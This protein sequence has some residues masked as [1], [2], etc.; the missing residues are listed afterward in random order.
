MKF[1]ELLDKDSPLL[2]AVQERGFEE[3]TE[4][5]EKSI[6]VILDGK[7]VIAGASTGSGK[8]LAFASGLIRNVKMGKGLQGLVL[9]PTRELAEQVG[10]ELKDFAKEIDLGVAIVYGGVG[11]NPQI[12]KLET[13]EIVVATPGRMLD[14][15]ERGSVD[16]GKINTIVLD[17]AD[18]MLDMGFRD[19]VKKIVTRCPANDRQVLLFSATI[20]SDIMHL[21]SGFM[22]GAV[23]V[24]AEDKVDPT[25][26]K[27]VYYDAKD[28][29][30][31]SLLK[32]LLEN[33]KSH[34][35]LVFCNTR[36][37]VDFIVNNLRALDI[38]ASPIHGGITQDKRSKTLASFKSEN[39]TNILVATDVAARG[40]HIEGITHVY[41][42]DS[43]ADPKEYI[44]RIGRTARAGKEGKVINIISMRDYENFNNLRP[45]ELGIKEE[46]TP[47]V[48]MVPIKW[49]PGRQRGSLRHERFGVGGPRSRGFGGGSSRGGSSRGG[50]SRGGSSRD[51]SRG[52]GRGSNDTRGSRGSSWGGSSGG[53]DSGRSSGGR[54]SRDSGRS[55]GGSRSRDSGSGSGNRSASSRDSG[56][57]FGGSRG[58]D[59]GRSSGGSSRGGSSSRDSGRGYGSNNSRGGSR[60]SGR[61]S[62]GSRGRDSRT[63]NR[64][65]S[66][67][68]SS[69]GSRGRE[70]GSRESGRGNSHS[71]VKT[72]SFRRH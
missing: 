4:I 17:E 65:F 9:T 1:E 57:S 72:K 63:H 42:Y 19:D 35:V 64:G 25:K 3:A 53:R 24:S 33:E 14:H 44:H 6:P 58:R 70:S 13:A 7:N 29:L 36:N 50:S 47:Y 54:G 26:L 10:K 2:V 21:S 46:E 41:N 45:K 30:K 16:L 67:S 27:Q 23:E 51:G 68:R 20:S 39:K 55:F 32:H 8:T 15:I 5:Q 48:E 49:I 12:K 28:N 31:F 62:G 71:S 22:K 60:G 34:L 56:R 69:G 11:I 52:G 59:S 61:S 37:N 40:L 18:R 38:N 43:P 66:G